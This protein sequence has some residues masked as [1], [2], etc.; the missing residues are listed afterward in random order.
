VCIIRRYSRKR[1]AWAP[2]GV[3]GPRDSG[4]EFERPPNPDPQWTGNEST[5]FES[6]DDEDS[7]WQE[8]DRAR[9]AADMA[10]SLAREVDQME[11]AHR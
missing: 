3:I 8:V 11:K 6:K 9:Q 1:G 4:A 5:P 10:A 7:C 2:N